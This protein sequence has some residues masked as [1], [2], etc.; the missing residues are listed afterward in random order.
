MV[1]HVLYY[2][3]MGSWRL[4]GCRDGG[5]QGSHFC[6]DLT[7]IHVSQSGFDEPF[8]KVTWLI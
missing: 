7:G 4:G 8:C 5:F 2:W 3:R 1:L 6:G